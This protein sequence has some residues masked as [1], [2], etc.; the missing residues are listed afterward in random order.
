MRI[1]YLATYNGPSY[2]GSSD[3]DWMQGFASIREAKDE[4]DRRQRMGYGYVT[5]YALNADELYVPWEGEKKYDFPAT[6]Q[7]D[8]MELYKVTLADE[9]TYWRQP[10]PF[11]RLTIG[12]RGGVQVE[13]Y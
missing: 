12:P 9:G 6:T 5:T 1:K 3:L 11:Y 2:G 4:M 8:F 7:D 10:E 13:A